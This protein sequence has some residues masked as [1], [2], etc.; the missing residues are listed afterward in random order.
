MNIKLMLCIALTTVVASSYAE[1]LKTDTGFYYPGNIKSSPY[2][3]FDKKVAGVG[4]H[5]AKDYKL[6]KGSPVYAI[7]SGVVEMSSMTILGY[8]SDIGGLGGAIVIKHTTADNKVFYALYGHI[9]AFEVSKG[10]EVKG[11]Q[12]IAKV[13]LYT[14]NGAPLPHLH[15]GINTSAAKYDGYTQST[16]CTDYLGFVDPEEYI[17]THTAK[18]SPAETCE[19]VDDA[20][21]TKKNTIVTIANVLAND[22]DTN[23][24]VLSVKAADAHS[25]QGVAITNNNDG[26]FTYTPKIDFM[27]TDTFSYTVT[28]NNG[29]TDQ[30]KVTISVNSNDASDDGGDSDS[31]G[32]NFSLLGLLSIFSISLLSVFRR[33]NP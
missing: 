22:T 27:G 14:A 9:N 20:A 28:D 32:G 33:K 25:K 30:A 8:G 11:G 21:S 7:S 4:C 31:G 10:D 5:L 19:A 12:P 15:F 2:Y 3:S 6:T 17:T 23:G 29:C 13:G 16:S 18:I 1:Q 24:D 26:T